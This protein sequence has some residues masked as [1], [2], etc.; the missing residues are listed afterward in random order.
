MSFT[1]LFYRESPPVDRFCSYI[2][3]G[4]QV[5][6]ACLMES[7]HYLTCCRLFF[8]CQLQNHRS[9]SIKYLQIR[10]IGMY[11]FCLIRRPFYYC[12][13]LTIDHHLFQ[14]RKNKDKSV[15]LQKNI[16]P[17]EWNSTRKENTFLQTPRLEITPEKSI[18]L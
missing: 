6:I 3:I 16:S 4:E 17:K 10:Y 2:D 1:L 12:Y 5:E 11:R 13:L 8:R 14:V 9:R 7:F 18:R 15:N